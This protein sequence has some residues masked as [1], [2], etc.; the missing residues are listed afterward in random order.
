VG[1]FGIALSAWALAAAPTLVLTR[2]NQIQG[3]RACLWPL[4]QLGLH[5]FISQILFR[6]N[7]V[8]AFAWAMHAPTAVLARWGP[9][10]RSLAFQAAQR[11]V[12]L[13]GV[14]AVCLY[15]WNIGGPAGLLRWRT[16]AHSPCGWSAQLVAVT[17][18]DVLMGIMDPVG[19]IVMG[20]A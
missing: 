16:G 7:R 13:L 6:H 19:S 3:V 18:V 1:P 12:A 8:W 4:V 14:A 2:A 10:K 20:G 5:L 9:P 15:A 17:G 11:W